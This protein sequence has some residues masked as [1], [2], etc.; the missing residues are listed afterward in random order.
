MADI[1]AEIGKLG[2][3]AVATG[4]L[5]SYLTKHFDR[6]YWKEE[7]GKLEKKI[8][9]IN[10]KKSTKSDHGRLLIRLEKIEE[11]TD[12]HKIKI[13]KLESE[14]STNTKNINEHLKL[15][16]EDIK[17]IRKTILEE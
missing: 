12:E 3:V 14:Y 11:D 5:V 7:I 9:V 15:I 17:E 10:G 13:Q 2:A 6:K 1:V 16:R 4:G 8:T